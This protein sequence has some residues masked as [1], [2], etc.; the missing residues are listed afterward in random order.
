MT[1]KEILIEMFNRNKIEFKELSN[2]TLFIEQG[3]GGFVSEFHFNKDG[4][5]KSVEAYE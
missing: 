5:L 4:S 2:G 1:D 3:Y